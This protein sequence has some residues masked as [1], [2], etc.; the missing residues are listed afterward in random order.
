MTRDSSF[1]LLSFFLVQAG[2]DV[3]LSSGNHTIAFV[4]G[5]ESYNT[6]K[7]AFGAVFSEINDSV[8]QGH[9]V[10]NDSEYNVEFFPGRRL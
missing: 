10:V 7:G 8:Y 2:D 6:L 1:I 9:I 5:S 4:K 3:M